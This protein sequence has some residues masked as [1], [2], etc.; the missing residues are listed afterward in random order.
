[1]AD[2]VLFSDAWHGVAGQR[3]ALRPDVSAHRQIWRGEVWH[4]LGDPYQNR[5][6]RV[7]PEAWRFL[8]RLDGR[9]SVEEAWRLGLD[10]DPEGTPG[11]Q[12]V[13]AL[14][15]QLHGAGLLR[16]D[17]P[18]DS[19]ALLRRLHT[20]RAREVRAQALNFLF[21]RIPLCDP[22]RLLR[23]LAPLFRAVFSRPGL[24]VWMLLLAAGA[25][26]LGSH[27][28]RFADQTRSLLAPGNL[29]WLYLGWIAM[30]LGHEFAHAGAVCRR[31]GEVHVFG[32]MLLVFTPVPYMDASA[33]WS[34]RR[35]RDRVLVGC[36]GVMND[37][38][39]AAAAALVWA[40]TGPGL[41]NG[42]AHNLVVLGSV[43][44]LLFNANP[45]LR[46]D[47]Y[48]VLADLLDQP[49]LQQRAQA[50]VQSTLERRAFG[51][52][53]APLVARDSRE[54]WG[55]GAFG[56]ASAL[57]R[58]LVLAAIVLFVAGQWFGLG[59]AVAAFGLVVWGLV[60][61]G[62]FVRYLASAP[63][64]RRCRSRAVGVSA[65]FAAALAVLTLL[66]P[67]PHHFRAPGVVRAE[68]ATAVLTGAEGD[69]VRLHA[70]SGDQVSAGQLL[71][72]LASPE[73][74]LHERRVAAQRAEVA[75]RLVWAREAQPALLAPLRARLEA[76]ER[77]LAE[78]TER[79]EA[80][81]V[82]AP[83][84]GLWF[85][86]RLD[87]L[88]G[89][90]VP[91]GAELGTVVD[92]RSLHFA[93]IVPQRSAAAL[94]RDEIRRGEVWLPGHPASPLRGASWVVL[95]AER[96]RLPTASLGWT[97]GG[98]VR[99]RPTEDGRATAEPFFEVRLALPEE[100]GLH[101]LRAGTG[102]FTLPPTPLARQGWLALRRLL[103]ERYQL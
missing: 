68:R 5:W 85:A 73:L 13:L 10:A 90:R 71:V 74:E 52:R 41:V 67:W 19:A 9:R 18:P 35:R 77:E 50:Q 30:K 61:L 93:T 70:R 32:V 102:R 95:P 25:F 37:L 57:Y 26:A 15:A 39:W 58:V 51:R 48:Y 72:E 84:D 54:A 29:A 49:N 86:P 103:Q 40:A 76:V 14:L 42:L 6:H 63:G 80:L 101:H 33:A 82:L 43:S 59:L 60:P 89:L 55:L 3:P 1:M 22:H 47:G 7:R 62:R 2:E 12:E 83:H 28:E 100:A 21:L 97:A 20:R 98:E 64:L 8:A 91:R 78:L 75:A 92:P 45:L 96:S 99:V 16:S 34:F 27:A 4:V 23:V 94:F 66:V 38:A 56:V 88:P 36:A 24:L 53:D 31:G 79:R 65:G 81:R 17:L 69:V 11:Q 46:F 87:T 44:T